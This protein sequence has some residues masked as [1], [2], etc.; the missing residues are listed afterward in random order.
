MMVGAVVDC[1]PIGTMVGEPSAIYS[2]TPM[3]PAFCAFVT[4]TAKEHVPRSMSAKEPFS[5][6]AANALQPRPCCRR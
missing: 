5:D 6:P 4:F 3:A 1:R 2:T